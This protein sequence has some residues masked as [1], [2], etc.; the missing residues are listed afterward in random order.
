LSL[1]PGRPARPERDQ[2]RLAFYV[3][4][5]L[6]EVGRRLPYPVATGLAQVAGVVCASTMVERRR[7]IAR[8]LDRVAGRALSATAQ[9][10]QVRQAFAS[11]ARYWLDSTRATADSRQEIL[12]RVSCDG[13]EHLDA[14][15]AAGRGVIIALPHLGSWDVG[16]AW[17]ALRHPVTVV[18]EPV[19]PQRL[20]EWMVEKRKGLGMEVVPLGPAA[21]TAVGRALRQGRVVALVSDRDLSG[22]G[23]E[24][25]F[26]GERTQLPG[27]PATLALRS[28]APLLPAAV[29]IHPD[30]TT[31]GVVRPPMEIKRQASLR[32]DV[33]RVTQ[34]I[35]H[36]LEALIRLAPE[37]WHLFQ[38]NW[39]SDPGYRP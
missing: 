16:G 35:A 9:R 2:D 12:S 7:L 39:P 8:H 37:Q 15:V 34:A 14:A 28:G 5:A 38:P 31:R 6:F 3:Y 20:F 13:L 25:E 1:A 27:G 36:E 23:V 32:E 10:R 33:V 11:Y 18:V 30:G 17:L 24:V 4:R 19:R 22:T 29:Y 26:F 21:A